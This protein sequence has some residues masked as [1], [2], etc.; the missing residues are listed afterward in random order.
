M[1]NK[2][3]YWNPYAGLNHPMAPYH[4][5]HQRHYN[6]DDYDAA[7]DLNQTTRVVV[8]GAVLVGTLGLLGGMMR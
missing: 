2:Q 5:Q 7:R 4:Y 6:H 3:T 1:R 8:G